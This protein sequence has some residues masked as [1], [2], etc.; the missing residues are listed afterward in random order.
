MGGWGERGGGGGGIEGW[1]VRG[2]TGDIQVSKE[3]QGG[4]SQNNVLFLPFLFCVRFSFLILCVFLPFLGKGRG[5]EWG[6]GGGGGGICLVWF[7]LSRSKLR[8]SDFNNALYSL[9][10]NFLVAVVNT[11]NTKT[12]SFEKKK[13]IAEFSFEH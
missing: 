6:G 3:Y 11:L 2:G 9:S 1:W 4:F 7:G 13:K 8:S 5:T 10:L 12:H